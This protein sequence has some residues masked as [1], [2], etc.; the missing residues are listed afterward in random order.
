MSSRA[1]SYPSTRSKMGAAIV[2]SLLTAGVL[3]SV[4]FPGT[5][6]EKPELLRENITEPRIWAIRDG[7][8]VMARAEGNNIFITASPL[9]GGKE[10]ILYSTPDRGTDLIAIK[11]SAEEFRFLIPDPG[12]GVVRRTGG[13]V[14]L[15]MAPVSASASGGGGMFGLPAPGSPPPVSPHLV[16]DINFLPP[17]RTADAPK[18]AKRLLT[19]YPLPTPF[20]ETLHIVPL[21]GRPPRT[22]HFVWEG[23]HNRQY[24]DDAV[25]YR[26]SPEK[27]HTFVRLSATESYYEHP[28]TASL[29]ARS[30]ADGKERL[31]RSGLALHT[32]VRRDETGL[33]L[34]TLRPYPNPPYELIHF[35]ADGGKPIRIPDYHSHSFPVRFQDRLWWVESNETARIKRLMRNKLISCRPDGSDRQETALDT[36]ADGRVISSPSLFHF[37]E[38]LGVKYL[39][40]DEFAPK[41]GGEKGRYARHYIASVQTEQ[42]P[43]LGKPTL[44]T[45]PISPRAS[46]CDSDYCYYFDTEIR[47]DSLDFLRERYTEQKVGIF[48]RIRLPQ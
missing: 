23:V 41:P 8:L 7:E 42:P 31:V 28:P 40:E 11:V 21:D 14:A 30:L 4:F 32:P 47:T 36:D 48:R 5:D 9:R 25:Y 19:D 22:Q 29:Y 1:P 17:V 3:L 18:G 34:L 43:T 20:R 26:R 38:R 37:R 35:P 10:R 27:Q 13:I 12:P 46:E 6:R 15:P 33:T 2:L 39:R 24:F 45:Y 16:F 44:L